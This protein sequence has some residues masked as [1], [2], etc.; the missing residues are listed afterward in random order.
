MKRRCEACGRFLRRC[1]WVA[2]D[3]SGTVVT[4]ECVKVRVTDEG[5][6]DHD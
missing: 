4:Y 2:P 1:E 5:G 6:M 3:G